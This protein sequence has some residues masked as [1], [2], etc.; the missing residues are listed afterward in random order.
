MT[1]RATLGHCTAHIPTPPP[2]IFLGVDRVA[3]Q[4]RQNP[5]NLP[6]Q[7]FFILRTRWGAPTRPPAGPSGARGRERAH[8]PPF[9]SQAPS[10]VQSIVC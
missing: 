8:V 5:A 9:P 2:K 6:F 7:I 4:P 10:C 3:K 1:P